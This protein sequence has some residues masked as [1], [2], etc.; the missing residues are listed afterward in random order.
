MAKFTETGE[1]TICV[2][3][4]FAKSFV[5]F[6][7]QGDEVVYVGQ[8]KKGLSRPFSHDDKVYDKVKIIECKEEELTLLE[9]SYI[10]KYAPMYNQTVGS[11]TL[12]SMCTARNK[13]RQLTEYR[14]LTIPQL[15]R[16]LSDWD[17]IPVKVGDKEYL[18]IEDLQKVVK[19]MEDYYVSF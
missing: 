19:I 16:V 18:H 9:S 14:N 3:S 11:S 15:R 10:A 5:Y 4:E 6:L 17:I 2:S 7:L 12:Y 13:L 1:I 8:T